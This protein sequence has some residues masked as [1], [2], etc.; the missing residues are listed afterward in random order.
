[1]KGKLFS[2]SLPPA[3]IVAP[4]GRIEIFVRE[5]IDLSSSQDVV[6]PFP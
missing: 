6:R 3:S 2:V 5:A 4:F 1:M